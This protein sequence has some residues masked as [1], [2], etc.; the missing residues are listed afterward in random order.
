MEAEA[1]GAEE[2]EEEV[3]DEDGDADTKCAT[4]QAM[5]V[6]AEA[7]RGA[8]AGVS[9]ARRGEARLAECHV[10][11]GGEHDEPVVKREAEDEA[12]AGGAE[13]A[14]EERGAQERGG[15]GAQL[16]RPTRKRRANDIYADKRIRIGSGFQAMHLP[17]CTTS[18]ARA[19][20]SAAAA[21]D[22]RQGELVYSGGSPPAET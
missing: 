16:L 14:A 8:V 10:A 1:A 13:A 15:G 17:R 12:A 3:V 6:E 4:A 2:E 19:S 9:E 22:T 5:E 11:N 21:A 18:A 20:F 7:S